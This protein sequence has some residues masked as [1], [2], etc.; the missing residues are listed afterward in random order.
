MDDMRCIIRKGYEIEKFSGKEMRLK[1]TG[2]LM[3]LLQL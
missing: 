2:F 1:L 3:M